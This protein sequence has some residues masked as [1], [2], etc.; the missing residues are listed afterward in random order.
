MTVRPVSFAQRRVW[1]ANQLADGTG[2]YNLFMALRLRGPLN[3]AALGDSVRDV[4]RR[5]EILRTTFTVMDGEPYQVIGG[6]TDER[7]PATD[8]SGL[9][10]ADAEAVA[11]AMAEAEVGRPFDLATGPLSRFMLYRI[12]RDDHVFALV[13]HHIAWDGW[14]MGLFVA[15]LSACYQAHV[16]GVSPELPALPFQY[17]E[18][19]ARQRQDAEGSRIAD[20]VDWWRTQL[21][22]APT[23]D[24]P[25]TRQRPAVRAYASAAV[26]R[27]LEVRLWQDTAALARRERVT[28]F[29][30]LLAGFAV[31]LSRL[32]SSED[33][34][35]GIPSV[36]RT[37]AKAQTLIGMFVNTLPLRIDLSGDPTFAEVLRRVRRTSLAAFAR[38]DVP[39]E[40]AGDRRP[41]NLRADPLLPVLFALQQPVAL[42][43]LAE[44]D[45]GVFPLHASATFT[46]LWLDIRPSGD[47][48]VATFRYRTDLFD[49]PTVTLIARRYETVLRAALDAPATAVA[50]LPLLDA[51]E[52]DT[53][54]RRWP[55][56]GQ[57]RPW[58]LPVHEQVAAQATRTPDAPALVF[59]DGRLTYRE[60]AQRV[61]RLT[62][63]LVDAG[64]TGPDT[65]IGLC[66]PRCSTLVVAVLAVLGS[67][68]AYLPLSPDDPPGR[69][70]GLLSASG[71]RQLVTLPE[72]APTFASAQL[73]V[74]EAADDG[75]WA[76]PAPHAGRPAV[77]PDDLAYVIYTSGSTGTPKAVAV[78]HAGL[79]NRIRCM[80]D[81]RALSPADRV[82]HKT[83]CTFDVSV[84]ELL[85]PLTAGATLVIAK[86]GGHRDPAYLVDVVERE[87]ITTIHFVPPMLEVFLDRPDL[88]RCG[89]LTR[90]I[91]SGQ[92]LSTRLRERCLAALP[93]ARLFNLYGPTEASIEVTDWECRPGPGEA[94]GE[95]IGRPI[96][97]V[98]TYVLDRELGPAPVGVAGE[99]YLGGVAL[100]R[101]YLGRPGMTA[102]RFVPHPFADGERLYRT[103]DVARWRADGALEFLGR[104]DDQVKIRGFRIEPEEIATVAAAHSDVRDAV[105]MA[106]P[107]EGGEPRLVAYVVPHHPATRADELVDE[108]RQLLRDQLPEYMVPGHVEVLTAL[109]L[110]ANGKVDRAAL[111]SPAR[112]LTAGRRAPA[113]GTERQLADIWADVLGV[114]DIGASD[115]F[116]ALGGD[117]LRCVQASHRA[118]AAGLPVD[119]GDLFRHP[120]IRELARHLQAARSADDVGLVL[121]PRDRRG[122]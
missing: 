59:E 105:V 34:V 36:G 44:M 75:D 16:T 117:S 97:G 82:L 5:H 57:A 98:R 15:E 101:G 84:W 94:A 50:E 51:D 25:T 35:V 110:T 58:D 81:A 93:G 8:L 88:N 100:A 14:S 65:V 95:P 20:A 90:I 43:T 3:A 46:D 78:P 116:F 72:L 69:L 28:P 41:E 102:D 86:P 13:C 91:A 45:V 38:Q 120:T 119:V 77:Q 62:E 17:A 121:V 6:S 56:G 107:A 32:S 48:A 70:T 23:L 40:L 22:G 104:N 63:R 76:H 85:W 74:H 60:L 67:G 54:L 33:V 21:A 37:S 61:S 99:L 4:V 12:G 55:D 113:D 89:S 115:D 11:R 30:V 108:V 49:A 18:H 24:L 71:A 7:I 80:Q 53:V 106:L 19:A 1:L 52:H 9:T 42:P 31:L 64:P 114:A 111:P 39:L 103:G 68:S 118:Q 73:P 47:T 87:S 112:P 109:P 2:A 92:V 79:A 10:A 83:P 27:E 66:L 96:P 122:S 26:D 29:M